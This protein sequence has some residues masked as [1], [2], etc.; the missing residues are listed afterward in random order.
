MVADSWR[1]YIDC[2]QCGKRFHPNRK[3]PQDWMDP[4]RCPC[5]GQKHRMKDVETAALDGGDDKHLYMMY[6]PS[7]GAAKIGISKQPKKR[8]STLESARPGELELIS[9]WD[10]NNARR[11]EKRIH[12]RLLERSVGGEWFEMESNTIQNIKSAID[13]FISDKGSGETGEKA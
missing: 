8:K 11:A 12:N 3:V 1:R 9:T 7:I 5:C 10:V 4:K 6:D 13:L 2:V